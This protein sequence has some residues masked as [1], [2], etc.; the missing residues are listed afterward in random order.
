MGLPWNSRGQ[1][2]VFQY[3]GCGLDPMGLAAKKLKH[4]KK[5]KQ[6]CNKFN[7]DFKNGPHQKIF[8]F[9][10]KAML[11]IARSKKIIWQGKPV[12]KTDLERRGIIALTGKS[13]KISIYVKVFKEN[14]NIL[15]KRKMEGIKRTKC[16]F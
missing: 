12:N 9:L 11:N 13:I 5:Q 7:K 6:Q 16:T 2:F 15:L 10:N 14:M 8:F 3:R 1:D 4:K